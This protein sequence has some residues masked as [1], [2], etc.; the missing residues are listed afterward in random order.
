MSLIIDVHN[1]FL[2]RGLFA[3][4]EKGKE[5]YGAALETN[6]QGQ[7]RMILNGNPLPYYTAESMRLCN[8][9]AFP[10]RRIETAKKN[11][12]LDVQALSVNAYFANYHLDARTGSAFCREVNEELA[13]LQGNYP[14]NFAGI[15]M[16]PWQDA[17]AALRELEY[18][19][20]ELGLRAVY[21]S[22]N[23]NGRDL[24]DAGL[25]PIFEAI[26]SAGLFLLCCPAEP[27]LGHRDRL[28]RHAFQH[29]LGPPVETTLALMSVIFGGV[30]D[31]FP[32]L[33][34][35]FNQAGGFALYNIGRLSFAYQTKVEARTMQ[36]PPEE[37]LRRVYYDCQVFREE[38]LKFAVETVGAGR[39]LVGT[40]YPL[41]WYRPDTV[42][43]IG[44]MSFLSEMEKK[45][46]LGETAAGL[47]GLRP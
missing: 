40:D 26:A 29:S 24:D 1:H 18:A 30:L 41:R 21:V 27:S 6:E 23:I 44:G 46:I 2:P 17:G 31:R 22:T 15:A 13:E 5:W 42:G 8:V 34:M 38:A 19:V 43:W 20:K 47:L 14:A 11:E 33:R 7:S 35:C 4:A 25:S 39:I 3:A 36:R 9:S 45:S 28:S 12:K 10:E 16:I 37:Y 32:D